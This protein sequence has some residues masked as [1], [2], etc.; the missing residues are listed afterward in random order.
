[1]SLEQSSPKGSHYIELFARKQ[2]VI[3]GVT[4]VS[5]F[6]ESFVEVI[7]TEGILCVE[8]KEL[9][10]TDLSLDTG[11]ITVEGSV[12]ELVYKDNAQGAKE[13]FFRRNC[14]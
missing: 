9:H 14:Y 4:E 8:G 1:M 2:L 7:T 6:D 5:G 10:M 3:G 12:D 13:G 11:K